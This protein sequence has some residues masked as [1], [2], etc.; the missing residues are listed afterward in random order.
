MR[1]FGRWIFNGLTVLSLV[2][3]LSTV[4]LWVRSYLVGDAVTWHRSRQDTEFFHQSNMGFT[5]ARG[6]LRVELGASRWPLPY[7]AEYKIVPTARGYGHRTLMPISYPNTPPRSSNTWEREL[8]G[9]KVWLDVYRPVQGS[10]LIYHYETSGACLILPLWAIALVF[11]L[12]FAAL[13]VRRYFQRAKREGVCPSCSYDLTG[14]V[15]GVCPECGTIIKKAIQAKRRGSDATVWATSFRNG[16]LC[17]LVRIGGGART[18]CGELYG[19]RPLL[20]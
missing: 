10:P 14:N 9:F 13:G 2:L 5:V 7:L 8:A 1:R 4:G 16:C 15:S 11:A 3:C 19:G 12:L 17:L 20:C 6:G 18:L